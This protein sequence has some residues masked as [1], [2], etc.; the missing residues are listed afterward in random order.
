M[1][2]RLASLCRMN[3]TAI[4]AAIAFASSLALTSPSARADV[5]WNVNFGSPITIDDDYLGAATEN[6]PSSTWNNL[7]ETGT[8]T[9]LT[10]NDSAGSNSAGVSLTLVNDEIGGTAI[11]SG[12][13]IFI[14]WNKAPGNGGTGPTTVTIENLTGDSYDLVIYADWFWGTGATGLPVTQTVGTGLA[15][16]IYVNHA[17]D[18]EGGTDLVSP[19][20]EDTDPADVAGAFNWY[21]ISGLTPVGGVLAFETS[22]RNTPFSGFQLIEKDLG[23]D[24]PPNPDPMTWD[25]V[26]AAAGESRITMTATTATDPG[27]VEY[28]FTNETWPDDTHD[29]GWQTGPTYTDTGLAPGTPYS[30]TV[31]ARDTN[32]N[33]TAPSESAAATTDAEDTTAPSPDPMTFASAPA[34][35]SISEITMTATAATDPDDNGVEYYFTSTS[36]GGNDSGWQD[37]P[38]YTDTGLVPTT[39]YAYTVKARDKSVSAN[40]TAPSAPA[41]ATTNT[42]ASVANTVWNVNIGDNIDETDNYVGAAPENTANSTW[43]SVTPDVFTGLTLADSTGST[44]AGVTLA[45]VPGDGAGTNGYSNTSLTT[46]DEIFVGW[47]KSSN[48]STPFNLVIDNLNPAATYD[49]VI[50]SDWFWDNGNSGL[51]VTQ[52][53]GTGLADTFFINR[54]ANNDA[55]GL[56]GPLLEDTDPADLDVGKTNYHRFIGLAPD[57]SGTLSFSMGGINGPL[58]GLQL[59]AAPQ[60]TSL[61]ITEIVYTSDDSMLTLTWTSSPGESYAVK[62]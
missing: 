54:D 35:V 30:Y 41:E 28:Y 49:L 29:S 39:T 1:K 56:V 13:K 18:G 27:G 4:A 61:Q 42:P 50:Y 32:E 7:T 44:G 24:D 34:A 52:T 15:D 36:G 62:F 60:E 46:G 25:S 40:E 53:A 23:D 43:N 14:G 38:V 2:T 45:L 8:T 33:T 12:D 58:S 48:N 16:T 11:T 3:R 51:P 22:G 9:G 55:K 26:P 21:R 19:L 6:T 37:D 20:A 59:I 17:E 5:V 57:G 47:T 31:M 10:L